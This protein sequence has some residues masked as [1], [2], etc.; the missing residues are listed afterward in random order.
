[1]DPDLE[2]IHLI[3]RGDEP[4]LRELIIRHKQAVFHFILRFTGN[5][6][7][8]TELTEETFVKVYFGAPKF[9]PRAKVKTWIFTIASNL[10]KDH[11]RKYKRRQVESLDST[12]SEDGTSTLYDQLPSDGQGADEETETKELNG[13]LHQQ[14]HALPEKLKIPFVHCVLEE[15]SHDECAQILGTT[16]K[17]VETRIYRA[18]KKLK[19]AMDLRYG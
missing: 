9:K 18:R 19:A 14:I 10:C 17:T 5:D 1:M 3:Q 12:I 11:F 7:D 4:A 15:R 2:L 13:F 16:S 6:A 8:A